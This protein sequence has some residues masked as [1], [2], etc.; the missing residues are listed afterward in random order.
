LKNVVKVT[1]NIPKKHKIKKAV[2]LSLSNN[3]F[4]INDM[5][6]KDKLCRPNVV[7]FK[8]KGGG[9]NSYICLVKN[10]LALSYADMITM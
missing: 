3:F 9:K 6:C 8:V 10:Y 2:I 1:S 4:F 5:N 7:L